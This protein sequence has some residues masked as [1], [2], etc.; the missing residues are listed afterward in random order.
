MGAAYL[1][2][3]ADPNLQDLHPWLSMTGMPIQAFSLRLVHDP[4]LSDLGL[5]KV[6]YL[7][8]LK[9]LSN[10]LKTRTVLISSSCRWDQRHLSDSFICISPGYCTAVTPQ[11]Q[12]RLPTETYLHRNSRNWWP[13]NSIEFH[14]PT[15]EGQP[16]SNGAFRTSIRPSRCATMTTQIRR[17]CGRLEDQTKKFSKVWNERQKLRLSTVRRSMKPRVSLWRRK[18]SQ[19]L[20]SF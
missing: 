14:Q 16:A 2:L 13:Q 5:E 3:L 12:F 7:F 10:E 17:R 19:T 1:I 11:L 8:N 4:W 18:E 6:R 15:P 20:S 9:E